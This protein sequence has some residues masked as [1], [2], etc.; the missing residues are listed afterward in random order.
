MVA[1]FFNKKDLFLLYIMVN[2]LIPNKFEET[3]EELF[4]DSVTKK[5]L[6]FDVFLMILIFLSAVVFVFETTVESSFW[7]YFF[8]V[9][10]YIILIIFSVEL[11]LRFYIAR[12][13]L[14]FFTSFYTWIDIFAVVPFW[15]G[16]SSQTIRMFRLFRIFRFLR[17]LNISR[18]YMQDEGFSDFD[19]EK[20]FIF[21]IIF[22]VFMLMFVSSAMIYQVEYL[23]NDSINSFWDSFYF[24]LVSVTTV[25][26]GDITPVT[27]LAKGILMI[28]IVSFLVI[29][30]VHITT[31]VKYLAEEKHQLNISCKGCGVKTHPKDSRHCRNCGVELKIR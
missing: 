30:P 27:D 28:S 17:F 5:S 13:K 10:D 31:M 14:N 3:L 25:G 4:G 7:I 9:L 11:L 16:F 21:R 29:V 6:N 12:K 24:V 1:S 22:T 18:K 23:V 26:Y 2:K 19:L 15:F 20:L 8:K